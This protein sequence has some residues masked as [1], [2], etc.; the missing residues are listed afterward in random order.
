MSVLF[1]L[2]K[3]T[4]QRPTAW[5]RNDNSFPRCFSARHQVK[6][7]YLPLYLRKTSFSS[8]RGKRA[9]FGF[10][11]FE[12][13]IFFFKATFTRPLSSRRLTTS[14]MNDNQWKSHSPG[15]RKEPP[16]ADVSETF[17]FRLGKAD[18]LISQQSSG[19][20]NA[21]FFDYQSDKFDSESLNN[22]META[23]P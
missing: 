4:C 13:I 1:Q 17:P 22:P 12:Q 16:K 19:F 8:W 23:R 10:I 3:I 2:I 14:S 7:K 9:P 11:E 6:L 20:F 18:E 15:L 21:I 5:T